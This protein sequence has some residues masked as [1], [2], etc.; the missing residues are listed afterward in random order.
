MTT[1][2]GARLFYTVHPAPD[3]L[4]VDSAPACK[5]EGVDPEWF[6]PVYDNDGAYDKARKVCQRCPLEV[7]CG[8]WA[9]ERKA[10]RRMW[11]LTT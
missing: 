8:D 7:T 10:R 3:F 2:T 9:T 4:R 1:A 11:E 5:E 6:F